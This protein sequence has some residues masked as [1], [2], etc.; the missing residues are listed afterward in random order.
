MKTEGDFKSLS[1]VIPTYNEHDNAERLLKGLASVRG[2]LP[3]DLEIIAVDDYSPD[4]TAKTL[5]VVAAQQ[6]LPLR[7][8][9]RGGPRSLGKAIVEGLEQSRGE[10]VCVMDADL[11]H[12]PED[13]PR[14]L[15]ALDGA[16]GVVA[17]RY[18]RGSRVVSWPR[19]RRLVSLAATAFAQDLI[20]SD[21]SDPVSGFFVFRRSSLAGLHLTGIGNKPLLEIL[22]AKALTIHEIPYEFHNRVRGKSKLGLQGIAQFTRL[23][24]LLSAKSIRGGSPDIGYEPTEANQARNP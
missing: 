12:P 7:V 5:S 13:I 6:G 16:D 8:I 21:C 22:A 20:R 14:L 18:I 3:T 24:A 19:H 9:L 4:G 23:L 2:R 15:T 10:L 11:S 17:S 1:I